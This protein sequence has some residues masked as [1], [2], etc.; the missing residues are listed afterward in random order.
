MELLKKIE[1]NRH[2]IESRNYSALRLL[3]ESELKASRKALLDSELNMIRSKE[4]H[5]RV[6]DYENTF[7][8]FE[9]IFRN[10]LKKAAASLAVSR[11]GEKINEQASLYQPDVS[12]IF[13]L[14]Y[15]RF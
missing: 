7:G 5:V 15:L 1:E 13:I 2:T 8:S 11:N 10:Q 4:T 6:M 14:Q 3:V 9:P 12:N